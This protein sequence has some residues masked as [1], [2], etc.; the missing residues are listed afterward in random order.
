MQVRDLEME[1]EREQ[2]RHGEMTKTSR[3]HE[4]HVKEMT[5]QVDED[6]KTIEKLQDII[7]KQ[8]AQMKQFKTQVEDSVRRIVT[9]FSII[10]MVTIFV[11]SIYFEK[12]I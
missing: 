5:Y 3:H 11:K 1:L 8:N 9:T 7:D 2:V 4:R 12:V 6:K 10:N